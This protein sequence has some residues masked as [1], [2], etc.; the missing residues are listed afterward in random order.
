MTE[1]AADPSS[2][3]IYP[4]Q[5]DMQPN[6]RRLLVFV[7]A[8]GR[9]RAL[10]EGETVADSQSALLV[11]ELSHSRVYYFPREDVRLDLLVG[12]A[13]TSHCP[14]KG[15]ASYFAF[16]AADGPVVAWSYEDPI[17]KAMPLGG[18]VAFY[19]DHVTLDIEG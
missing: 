1:M 10:C 5:S 18:Y 15:D 2:V 4:A 13:Q 19:E 6:A 17:E 9:V 14:R 3:P 16:R 7:R 11:R 8:A 12:V